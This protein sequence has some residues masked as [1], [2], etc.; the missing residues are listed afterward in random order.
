MFVLRW[1]FSRSPFSSCLSADSWMWLDRDTWGHMIPFLKRIWMEVSGGA[2]AEQ[3]VQ[4]EL[5]EAWLFE[6]LPETGRQLRYVLYLWLDFRS[7][8]I[9]LCRKICPHQ[10][11]FTWGRMGKVA[12]TDWSEIWCR[13]DLQGVFFFCY[14]CCC[15]RTRAFPPL[16]VCWSLQLFCLAKTLSSVFY[17]P[18]ERGAWEKTEGF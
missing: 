3:T 7:S 1:M 6:E 18:K 8:V 13:L 17:W 5:W 9:W 11:L 15:V 2:L 12:V 10:Q 16:A 14:L 4:G